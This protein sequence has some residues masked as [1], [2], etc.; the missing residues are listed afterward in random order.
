M[1]IKDAYLEITNR[2]NLNC[3]Y[4]YNSSGENKTTCELSVQTI[5]DFISY[6]L[7]LELKNKDELLKIHLAGGEP[8]L[9]SQ[10]DE[11]MDLIEKY[12]GRVRFSVVTNGTL[13]NKRF[14]DLLADNDKIYVQFTLDGCDEQTN[15]LS[16]GAGFFDK[17][18]CNIRNNKFKIT[19]IL[20][21]VI[22]NSNKHQVEQYYRF[23][24]DLGC[25]PTFAFINQSGNAITN[26]NDKTLS[27]L[28]KLNIAN[29]LSALDNE[30]N[31]NSYPPYAT[32]SC[33]L[34]D[35][36]AERSILIKPNGD[37]Q[38]C[39]LLY[40][41]NYKLGNIHRHSEP[42]AKNPDPYKIEENFNKLSGLISARK[43]LDFGCK[44]CLCSSK[45]NKGCP[46]MAIYAHND[47]NSNDSLC[48][49]RKTEFMKIVLQNKTEKRSS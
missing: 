5:E 11:L 21:M 44:N 28:D 17:I 26:W 4:C 49:F 46:A 8:L 19:P 43:S 37:I 34:S 48:T 38:P 23:A 25:T 22:S 30:F 36:D 12:I 45:C 13:Y 20:K 35:H 15:A 42:K 14:Y 31:I 10:L 39:Q 32:L 6:L 40:D 2:C 7:S 27:A 9:Y 41:E 16:R 1:Y 18:L 24:V 3:Y 33:P 29:K 47:L